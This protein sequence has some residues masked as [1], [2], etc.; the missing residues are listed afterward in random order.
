[1]DDIH[2]ATLC[3]LPHTTPTVTYALYESYG[4]THNE[5]VVLFVI[6]FGSSCVFGTFVA[7]L[8]DVYGNKVCCLL[9][10]ITYALSC[11]VQHSNEWYILPLGR[12]L[13]GIATS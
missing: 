1:M 4:Y 5:I 13:G 10:C 11:I 12:V 3:Y 7:S 8:G 9:Y 6:G 2:C